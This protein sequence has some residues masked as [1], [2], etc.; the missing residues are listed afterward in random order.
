MKVIE[1]EFEGLYVFEPRVFKDERGYFLESYNA[2][3][4]KEYGVDYKYVQD[5]ESKSQYGTVRGL[6]YQIAPY[7]QVKI[8]RCTKG[9]VRDIVVDLRKDQPTY[10][11]SF[12]ITLSGKKKN[13]LLI[14]RG[15]AHGFSTLSKTAIFS[16]KCDNFYNQENEYNIHPLDP[17]LALDWKVPLSDMILSEKDKNGTKYGEHRDYE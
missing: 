11:K 16:Y 4:W 6:H 2:N 3:V 12:A 1:T 7:G 17:S 13:Q 10:G 9:K 5:N 14:P 15:F 8:V